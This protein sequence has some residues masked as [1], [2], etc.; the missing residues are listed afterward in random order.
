MQVIE[1]AERPAN[2][3]SPWSAP[4]RWL[5]EQKLSGE[6]WR[7]FSTAFFFDT[8]F[9]IY[10]FLFNLYLLDY[11]FNERAMG[12]IGGA[13]TLGLVV[14]TLPAG[15]LARRYGLRP[16]LLTLFLGAPLMGTARALWVWEPAQIVLAFLA[17]CVMSSWGVCFL[18]AVSRFTTEKNRTS[19]FSLIFSVSV[20]SSI[21]GGIVCGYLGV[22]LKAAGIMLPPV[23]V[24]R[25]I[26]LASSGIAFCGI[27]PVL[28]LKQL[29]A[30]LE[31][32]AARGEPGY[33]HWWTRWKPDPF[34]LRFL[35]AM[36]LWAALLAAFT[37]FANVYLARVLHV[38]MTRIGLVFSIV[39]V[40]QFGMGLVAPVLFRAMGLLNGI[41][42][43]QIGAAIL[44]G[45]MSLATHSGA[46]IALYLVFSA[47][48]WMSSPG[49]YN[50]LMD[51]TPEERRSTAAATTLCC[52]SL[53]GSVATPVAGILF[54]RFG[55][56][57][58]LFGLALAGL[59]IAMLFR[60]SLGSGKR[61][62]Q[63]APCEGVAGVET[64]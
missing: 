7:L 37:P 20:L 47:A 64:L 62:S 28:R 63:I 4:I 60:A 8:G 57:P 34:L 22:W 58:V 44:L 49:L 23:E 30:P 11:H 17:G 38:S 51:R 54:V 9:G 29:R 35:P 27:F 59:A 33:E 31:A 26:L 36:S 46:A 53:A 32:T 24:K 42:M 3:V 56:P 2:G 5:R 15:E 41:V 52:N 21:L 19:G 50:L 18:S 16:L 55:Y 10:F 40:V 1:P 39:Q 45:S 61:D 43:T 6:Y 14:G 13:L 25:L 12:W 48:Q